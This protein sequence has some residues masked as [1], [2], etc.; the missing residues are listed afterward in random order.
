MTIRQ[1]REAIDISD[2]IKRYEGVMETLDEYVCTDAIPTGHDAEK[3]I[4]R[5]PP[6]VVIDYIKTV[7]ADKEKELQSLGVKDE[8][9]D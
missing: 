8:D 4:L 2:S 9:G 5:L 3:I 6:S 1:C 7:I